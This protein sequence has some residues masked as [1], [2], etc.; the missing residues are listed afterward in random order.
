[1]HRFAVLLKLIHTDQHHFNFTLR[2]FEQCGCELSDTI[3]EMLSKR[4]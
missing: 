1:M 4:L 3:D 2:Y